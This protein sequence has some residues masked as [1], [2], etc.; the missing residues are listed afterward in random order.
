MPETTDIGTTKNQGKEGNMFK[1]VIKFIKPAGPGADFERY[2]Q[3]LQELD[4]TG[5]PTREQAKRDFR[6]L[7]SADPYSFYTRN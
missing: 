2:L 3:K 1:A 7:R 4:A 6:D 5:A